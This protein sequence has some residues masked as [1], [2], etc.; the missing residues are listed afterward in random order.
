[1]E[2]A[3]DQKRRGIMFATLKAIVRT[4]P[5][6]PYYFARQ[7]AALIGEWTDEDQA[8][9]DLY[10]SFLTSKNPLVFDIGAN[11]GR[12]VKIFLKL[13]C[14]V[15]AA[16]PQ[17]T[18]A[19]ALRH[20]FGQ[21]ITI[22]QCAISA[23]PGTVML[24]PSDIHTLAST[25]NSWISSVQNSGRFD[26]ARWLKQKRVQA[27]TL[28]QLIAKYGIPE[29]IKIDV[30]GGEIDVLRGL[31]H[32]VRAL[33]FELTPEMCSNSIECIK[34]LDGTTK[35]KYNFSIGDSG[36]LVFN[37]WKSPSEISTFLSANNQWGDIYALSS[38]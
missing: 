5:I 7:Q 35:Y 22:E 27:K 15:I 10:A 13:N 18:C 11:V 3:R 31:S 26:G 16:E 8:I 34:R 32:P 29:F 25:S 24:H 9:C 14:R 33:S 37:Q 17:K 23:K 19:T 2:L 1:M 20:I 4:S 36:S 38:D 6:Y 21:R 30:E 12:R 28:D